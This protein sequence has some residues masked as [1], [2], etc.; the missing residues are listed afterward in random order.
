MVIY[1]QQNKQV[2]D[3]ID[4]GRQWICTD[5]LQMKILRKD[6]TE[7]NLRVGCAEEVHSI[8]SERAYFRLLFNIEHT[9]H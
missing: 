8:K 3:N 4:D 1:S 2:E 7:G 9:Y 5:I 6:T